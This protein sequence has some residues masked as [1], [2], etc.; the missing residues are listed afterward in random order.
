MNTGTVRRKKATK[1]KKT[2]RRSSN[3]KKP[4]FFIPVQTEVFTTEKDRDGHP[5]TLRF[6]E[7][8]P[9]IAELLLTKHNT[10][11]RKKD[12]RMIKNFVKRME[13][14]EW[15]ING[16][17]VRMSRTG[18]L[19]DGQNRLQSIMDS[20]ISQSCIIVE[21]LHDDAFLTMDDGRKRNAADVLS[22][23]QDPILSGYESK[24]SALAK[25]IMLIANGNPGSTKGGG[26]KSATPSNLAVRNYVHEN[27]TELVTAVIEGVKIAKDF[28]CVNSRILSLTYC[29]F[30]RK[31]KRK[32]DDFFESLRTGQSLDK[33]SPILEF[34]NLMIK[35]SSRKDSKLKYNHV[36]VYLIKTW[37]AYRDGE[38]I[39]EFKWEKKEGFPKI[40]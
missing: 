5:I 37:N 35:D 11:N 39:N 25:S 1:S 33:D 36:L 22:A 12:L 26:D 3:L 9:E 31:N 30:G 27:K 34:R 40:K 32:C 14:D 23:E 10:R 17:T 38:T 19:L 21:G 15:M 24:V 29:L 16:D 28:A 4:T 18:I 2:S 7:I 13:G 8:T 6:G 20:G